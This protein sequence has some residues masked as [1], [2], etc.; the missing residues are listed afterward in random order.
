MTRLME[1]TLPN[2]NPFYAEVDTD[3]GGE[4]EVAADRDDIAKAEGRFNEGI[5]RLKEAANYVLSAF[6]ELNSPQEITLD[7]GVK[8]SGKA[9]ADLPPQKLKRTLRCRSSGRTRRL[10]DVATPIFAGRPSF[11]RRFLACHYL[12]GTLSFMEVLWTPT[13]VLHDDVW[14]ETL[15]LGIPKQQHQTTR[16]PKRGIEPPSQSSATWCAMPATLG[17]SIGRCGIPTDRL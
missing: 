7:F 13:A 5:D 11:R 8:L 1:F 6:K 14:F 2:G 3:I 12:A 10:G 16:H 17:S 15:K 4:I 9:G